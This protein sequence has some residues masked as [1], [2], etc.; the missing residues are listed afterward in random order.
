MFRPLI[1]KTLCDL[2]TIDRMTPGKVF[3]DQAAF[4]GLQRANEVPGQGRM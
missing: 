1:V 2:L 3:S 4:I